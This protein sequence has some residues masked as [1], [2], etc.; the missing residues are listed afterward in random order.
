MLVDQQE[1]RVD[2][3][4]QHRQWPENRLAPTDTVTQAPGVGRQQQRRQAGADGCPGA[5]AQRHAKHADGMVGQVE[6]DGVD[7]HRGADHQ[8]HTGEQ[9]SWVLQQQRYLAGARQRRFAAQRLAVDDGFFQAMT[10][11][12]TDRDAED[13]HGEHQ[14]PPPAVHG[15]GAEQVAQAHDH[16]TADEDAQAL[17]EGLPAA[18]VAA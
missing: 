2:R 3:Q 6:L 18:V 8:Q 17:A 10:D 5:D 16:Q 4:Q 14:A 11:V 13:A 12:L 1:R 7:R 9:L 15:L